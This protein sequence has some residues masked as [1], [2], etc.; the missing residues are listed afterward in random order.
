MNDTGRTRERL[1]G[2]ALAGA[3]ALN[4][5]LLYL[6]SGAGDPLGI[7]SLFFYLFLVWAGIIALVAFIIAKDGRPRA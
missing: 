5:P 6:F 4:F 2:V 3:V 7:P 1:V